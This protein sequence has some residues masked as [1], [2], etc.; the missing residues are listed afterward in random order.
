MKSSMML[1]YLL[2]MTI[3]TI[4]ILL[5][6]AAVQQSY[7]SGAN[8]PQIQVV[9]DMAGKL[10]KGKSAETLIPPDT[11]DVVSSLAT[12]SVAYS[13]DGKPLRSNGYLDGRM[14][15]LPQGVFDYL[16]DHVEDRVTWQPRE[17][18]R[19]AMVVLRLN[20]APVAFIAAGRSILE[21]EKREYSLRMMIIIAWAICFFLITIVAIIRRHKT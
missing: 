20:A 1:T 9:Y 2:S 16:K 3:I 18:V 4:L 11:V 7:R 17:G 19:M 14:I 10:L 13:S 12:V 15:T 8:D 6:Y 5:I 21:V